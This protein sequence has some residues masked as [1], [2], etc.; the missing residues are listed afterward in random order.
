ML[1]IG[2]T[3]N[4]QLGDL[5]L[6]KSG[7]LETIVCTAGKLYTESKTNC[8]PCYCDIKP[9]PKKHERMY[10]SV[11][12]IK[13]L[14]ED[15]V[16]DVYRLEPGDKVKGKIVKEI[17][18]VDGAV[19]F[20]SGT[21]ELLTTLISSLDL[22]LAIQ[23]NLKADSPVA[24]SIKKLAETMSMED[25]M[26]TVNTLKSAEA[27]RDFPMMRGGSLQDALG[28]IDSLSR[29]LNQQER[30]RAY[31]MIK[32]LDKHGAVAE[33]L[34]KKLSVGQ[35]STLKSQAIEASYRVASKKL[36]EGA[37]LGVS[38]LMTALAP[39]LENKHLQAVNDLAKTK[40]G[41][42]FMTYFLGW[43]MSNA[44]LVKNNE[45][46]NKLVEEL[47]VEGLLQGAELGLDSLGDLVKNEG[48][49]LV[50]SAISASEDN[51]KEAASSQKVRLNLDSQQEAP[52]ISEEES[53]SEEV[54]LPNQ[55]SL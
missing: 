12:H 54:A 6:M 46:L 44:E 9:P 53:D 45:V 41:K 3:Q 35:N 33:M 15:E 17:S 1:R 21:N 10:H 51:Q 39:S 19:T 28:N 2:N 27:L 49:S 7:K 18:N 36:S 24:E 42:A 29:S 4:A 43:L 22:K 13:E 25:L 55:L 37:H 14:P 48:L 26:K 50:K 31:D 20:Q 8:K 38:S 16:D 23:E 40:G 30:E 47:R 11:H 5:V 32:K 34:D 52:Q